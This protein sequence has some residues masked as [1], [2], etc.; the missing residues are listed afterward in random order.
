MTYQRTDRS[1]T[2]FCSLGIVLHPSPAFW[3]RL[4]QGHCDPPRFC[5]NALVALHY[6]TTTTSTTTTTL[7][8]TLCL[9][10]RSIGCRLLCAG[11]PRGPPDDGHHRIAAGSQQQRD[12]GHAALSLLYATTTTMTMRASPTPSARLMSSQPWVKRVIN[13]LWMTT[14]VCEIVTRRARCQGGSAPCRHSTR[15]RRRRRRADQ[16]HVGPG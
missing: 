11:T 12:A 7:V 14:S 4:M 8:R 10:S 9:V 13:V 15:A 2:L 1:S 3:A 5:S 16:F 6:Y